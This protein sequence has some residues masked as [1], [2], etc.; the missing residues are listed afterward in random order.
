[1]VVKDIPTEIMYESIRRMM[2]GAR[3]ILEEDS[4]EIP[5]YTGGLLDPD[6]TMVL[7]SLNIVTRRIIQLAEWN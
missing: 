3:H 6:M 7:A 1:M 5:D 2:D 4:F